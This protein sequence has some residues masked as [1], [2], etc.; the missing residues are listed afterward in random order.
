MDRSESL[1]DKSQ[2]AARWVSLYFFGA[3][4]LMLQWRAE[5]LLALAYGGDG[6]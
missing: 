5:G 1:P 3:V 6:R 4:L 2:E